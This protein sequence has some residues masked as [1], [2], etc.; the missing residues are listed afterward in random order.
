[1]LSSQ[2]ARL[3]EVSEMREV[4]DLEILR[5]FGPEIEGENEVS[6]GSS[7]VDR[8]GPG[9]RKRSITVSIKD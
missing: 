5:S 9:S 3:D 2:L 6:I 8:R 1:M 7:V 4:N